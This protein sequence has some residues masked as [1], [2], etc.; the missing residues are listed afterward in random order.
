MPYSLDVTEVESKIYG[1]FGD[2]MKIKDSIL[3]NISLILLG[4][5]HSLD[6][7]TFYNFDKDYRSVVKK[8]SIVLKS[9]ND[10]RSKY[11]IR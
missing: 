5:E 9:K 6:I 8:L 1:R 11:T 7:F 4:L 2:K 10:S 3:F